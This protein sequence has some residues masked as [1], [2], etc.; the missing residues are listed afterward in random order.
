MIL[1]FPLGNDLLEPTLY[2]RLIAFPGLV[3]FWKPSMEVQRR[4]Q[5]LPGR[6]IQILGEIQYNPGSTERRSDQDDYL[7]LRGHKMLTNG[8]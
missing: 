2:L 8:A 7:R 6:Y 1:R 5:S 3:L 4:D